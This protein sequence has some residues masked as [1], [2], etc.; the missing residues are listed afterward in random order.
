MP[1]WPVEGRTLGRTAP[2]RANA[3]ERR[4]TAGAD[5]ARTD[6]RQEEG[7]QVGLKISHIIGGGR[8]FYLFLF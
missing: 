8:Y 4:T 6:F 7:R 5:W 1:V 3:V 2:Q